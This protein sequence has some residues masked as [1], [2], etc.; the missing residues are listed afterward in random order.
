MF[1]CFCFVPDNDL[2]QNIFDDNIVEIDP[3]VYEQGIKNSG[4]T[5]IAQYVTAQIHSYIIW[6]KP[7]KRTPVCYRHI[8]DSYVFES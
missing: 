4:Y 3:G 8:C 5:R 7:T 1:F 2:L 6:L